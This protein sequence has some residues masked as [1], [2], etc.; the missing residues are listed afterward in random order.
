MAKKVTKKAPAAA[1]AAST[2]AA[3]VKWPDNLHTD[4]QGLPLVQPYRAMA[5]AA[6][7]GQR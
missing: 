4:E 7:A 2:E 6:R 5:K 3:E 1:Q